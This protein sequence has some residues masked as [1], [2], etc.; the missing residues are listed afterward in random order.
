M[1]SRKETE[2]PRAKPG[3]HDHGIHQGLTVVGTTAHGSYHGQTAMGFAPIGTP[4]S[5]ITTFLCCLGL[6]FMPW[7]SHLGPIG[8][9][10]ASSHD[11]VWLH[12]LSFLLTLGSICVN[13]QLKHQQVETKFNRRNMGIN[14]KIMQINPYK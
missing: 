10:F 6:R 11:L 13:L 14:C 1:K 5:R 7:I 12:F 2:T 3:C 8:L 4:T 9:P